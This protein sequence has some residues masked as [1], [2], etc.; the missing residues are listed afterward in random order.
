MTNTQRVAVAITA[1]CA[2]VAA[3]Y[4]LRAYAEG[5]PTEQPLFYSGILEREGVPAE[6]G[7]DLAFAL[8]DAATGGTQLCAGEQRQ[9]ELVQG[10]FRVAWPA[11][12]VTALREHR[13]TYLELSVKGEDETPH[14]LP[15]VKVGA[16]PYA[17]E[18]DRAL[19]ANRANSAAKADTASAGAANFRVA[20]D[21]TV[22]GLLRVGA[23][24]SNDCE[25]GLDGVAD[26]A[27]A[28]GELAISGGAYAGPGN[29]LSES[30]HLPLDDGTSAWRVACAQPNGTRIGCGSPHAICVRLG[31]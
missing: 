8:Y 20:G 24:I 3:G 22:T 26:C 5:A 17:L 30:R 31:Q 25:Y 10:H 23:R 19:S 27:C 4:G 7:H 13:E 12:C 11:A 2:C 1:A 15:R 14:S 29:M 6:G 28:A 21:A 16:V 9:V 18:A